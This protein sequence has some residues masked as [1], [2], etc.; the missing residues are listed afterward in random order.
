MKQG[1]C[2]AVCQ[3]TA[4]DDK[5]KRTG[6]KREMKKW[7]GRRR[8]PTELSH[9]KHLIPRRKFTRFNLCLC[10]GFFFANSNSRCTMWYHVTIFIFCTIQ[11]HSYQDQLFEMIIGIELDICYTS[12]VT[13]HD[14]KSTFDNK[15]IA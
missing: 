9:I 5:K 3:P 10:V 12:K 4:I 13:R 11:I 15:S 2:I 7:R 1:A 14:Y 6:R 8:V